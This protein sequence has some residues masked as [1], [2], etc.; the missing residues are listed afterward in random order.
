[1]RWI[2]RWLYDLAWPSYDCEG[3]H[4]LG[5]AYPCECA[6]YTAIAP[7]Y[8]PQTQHVWLRWLHGFIFIHTSPFWTE[9]PYGLDHPPRNRF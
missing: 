9:Y 3:C 2:N 6:Y 7:G 4:G 5:P 8:G 1:M